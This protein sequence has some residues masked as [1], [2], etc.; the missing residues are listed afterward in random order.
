[1]KTEIVTSTC[2]KPLNIMVMN[3]INEMNQKG[4]KLMFINTIPGNNCKE[5]GTN[6]SIELYFEIK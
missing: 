2:S 6:E 3:K 4:Y 5:Y 1:M